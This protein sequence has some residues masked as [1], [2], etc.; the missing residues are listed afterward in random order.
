MASHGVKV[1]S[2]DALPEGIEWMFVRTTSG[3]LVLCLAQSSAGNA[4]TLAEAWEA[5][6]RMTEGPPLPK[7]RQ[8]IDARRFA[9]SA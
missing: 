1:V 7:Q 3:G 4:R 6:R 5:Y 2:D 9:A 8:P